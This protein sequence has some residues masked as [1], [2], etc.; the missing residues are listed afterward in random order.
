M[1]SKPTIRLE[2]ASH[3]N[4]KVV[5]F[6]FARQPEYIALVRQLPGIRW[7]KNMGCWYQP[8]ELFDLHKAFDLLKSIF[9]IDYSAL[10]KEG[11]PETHTPR[12]VKSKAEIQLPEG[13]ME[14]LL[15][16]RYSENTIK[17][18][19]S[20]MLDFV[21]AMEDRIL[22]EI[23]ADEINDY[24]LA[25]IKRKKM[26]V[27]Q[28][29]QRINAIKFYYEKVLNG[30]LPYFSIDRPR[31][32]SK[33]P[34]V[35]SKKDI[36]KILDSTENLKHKCVISI[37]YSAGLR[38]SEVVNLRITDI[39]SQRMLIKVRNAKGKKDRY[40]SL[41]VTTL[42]DLRDYIRKDKPKVWLFEGQ[43]GGKYSVE[44]VA[45][46]LKS[47]VKRVGIKKRVTPHVLRH[48][49]ATHLLEQGIDLRYIQAML[50]HASS[51]TTEIYTHVSNNHLGNIN[52]PLD[53]P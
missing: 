37:L 33:L 8:E 42:N 10:K 46:A 1:V 41:S 15:Q 47:A 24:I 28:Q 7:S 13:F 4:K 31:K 52:N 12:E 11:G 26:S 30:R 25:L 48:S 16:K 3:Y 17:T 44:S 53:D 34:N 9:W 35:L 39:D 43:G 22:S 49:F 32:E 51:K 23:S 2:R 38:R 36:L 21:A 50:G 20:Y 18:Y 14:K 27:S 40:T 6:R 19:V 29:N 5:Q 45:K